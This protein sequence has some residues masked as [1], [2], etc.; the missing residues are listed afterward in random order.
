MTRPHADPASIHMLVLDVDGVLTA[1]EIIYDS[2]G[3]E[4]KQFSVRDGFGLSLWHAAG[5][6]SAIITARGGPVVERRAE[7][8]GIGHRFHR[9]PDK[10]ATLRSLAETTGVPV[11]Q[12]AYMGDDWK[13]MPALAIAGFPAAPPDAEPPVREMA[14]WVSRRPGGRG[15]VRELVEHL[16]EARGVLDGLRRAHGYDR[17]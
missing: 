3:R 1:G 5:G 15:A 12:M 4:L 14:V 7:E 2:E 9:V 17:P 8:L 13:D 11:E 10:A 6:Q 16:L